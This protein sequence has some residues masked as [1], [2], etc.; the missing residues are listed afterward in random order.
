MCGRYAST[1]SAEDLVAE[2]E[3]VQ[4]TF[5]EPLRPDY[6]VA[7]T[8]TVPVVRRSV[9]HAG[10]VVD[11]MRWGLVPAWADSLSAGAK[12]MN[13][14][15][16]SIAAKPAFRSA[17]AR[18]RC[19]IPADGWYEWSPRPD[20]AGKQA[21]YLSRVDGTLC[22]FAGVWEVWGS[23]DQRV[24]TCSIVTTA[25]IGP[26]SSVHHRM[27]LLL[28]RERWATWLGEERV[29]AADVPAA[30]LAPPPPAL[31]AGMDLR[32]VGAAVGN[33]RNNSPELRTRVETSTPAQR[34]AP[35]VPLDTLF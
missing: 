2:F 11:A 31:L 20:G 29:D 3:A 10:R 1:K 19:L 14:R 27:P 32:P 18:R 12:M 8:T 26:L 4:S 16:E 24:A 34:M 35:P 15:A 33:I 17:F 30:L 21:W 9:S 6:N 28:P 7:P 23:G 5:E 13:A 22:V 25:A